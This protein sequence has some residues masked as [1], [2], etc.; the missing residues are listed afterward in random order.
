MLKM[1]SDSDDLT[2]WRDEAQAVIRDV[3][4]HLKQAEISQVLQ[5]SESK[6][7]LNV[8]TLEDK[9]VTVRLSCQGFAV[10]C[11]T[12]HDSDETCSDTSSG[13]EETCHHHETL[14][15]LL[16]AISP[17]YAESFGRALSAKL[18]RLQ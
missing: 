5:S 15:S 3:R 18:S 16:N 6:I 4:D 14:Y 9:K 2:T 8:T 17:A 12:S 13:S 7:Y 11:P 1:E 10:V